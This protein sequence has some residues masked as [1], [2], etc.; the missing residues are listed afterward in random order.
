[1]LIDPPVDDDVESFAKANNQSGLLEKTYAI[2]L[3]QQLTITL[4]ELQENGSLL[5]DLNQVDTIRAMHEIN[6]PPLIQANWPDRF[7][8]AVGLVREISKFMSI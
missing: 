3:A 7:E 1:M 4:T 5:H 8:L 6:N 2:A